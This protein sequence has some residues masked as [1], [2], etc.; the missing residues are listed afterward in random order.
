MIRNLDMRVE[1]A[2]P[3]LD[4]KVKKEIKSILDLQLKDNTKARIINKENN[5]AY[6]LNDEQ[7]LRSQYE[8]YQLL[9][10]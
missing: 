2:I 8:T 4:H 10:Q 5:N 9:K 7:A 3:I 6:K 1:V